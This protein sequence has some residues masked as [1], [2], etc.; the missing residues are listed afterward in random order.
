[1]LSNVI[2]GY[3]KASSAGA[4]VDIV[5]TEWALDSYV[6][7]LGAGVFTPQD[8]RTILRPDAELLRDYGTAKEDAK[9]QNG[10]FWGPAEY[11]GKRIADGYKMKWHNLGPGTVQLR[12]TVYLR[13]GEA[14]LC[15]AYTKDSQSKEDRELAKFNNRTALIR[16][17]QY[18]TR[19]K[20]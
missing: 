7:L 15:H 3:R 18:V 11:R 19:G 13:D 9:F 1:M 17:G 5:I 2:I 16:Q 6:D 8:Y 10:K 4:A 20:L 12:L 14:L